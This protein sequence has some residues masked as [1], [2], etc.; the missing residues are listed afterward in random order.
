M[1]TTYVGIM[2]VVFLVIASLAVSI[3]YLYI[4]EDDMRNMAAA[5]RLAYL[6]D[7]LARLLLCVGRLS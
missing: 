6:C 2:L 4:D 5:N 7:A 3:G 1:D